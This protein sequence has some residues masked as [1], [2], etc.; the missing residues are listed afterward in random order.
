M[1]KA[2]FSRD[3]GLH[4][5]AQHGE[6]NQLTVIDPLKFQLSERPRMISQTQRVEGTTMVMGAFTVTITVAPEA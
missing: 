1:W 3:N 4:V 6:H 5:V 2:Q